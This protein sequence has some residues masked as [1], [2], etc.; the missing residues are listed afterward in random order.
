ME[1]ANIFSNF[2]KNGMEKWVQENEFQELY[3]TNEHNINAGQKI[4]E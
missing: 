1:L 2:I 4:H 3:Y